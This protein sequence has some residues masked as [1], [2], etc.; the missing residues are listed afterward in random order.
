MTLRI[1]IME[2]NDAE[3]RARQKSRLG[4]TA[5]D[6]YAGC[7]RFLA[8]DVAT[9]ICQPADEDFVIPDLSRIRSYDGVVITGS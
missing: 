7:I 6:N 1:L 4:R 2:G 3:G 9:D 8:P 5:S